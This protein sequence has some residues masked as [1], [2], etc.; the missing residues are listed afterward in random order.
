MGPFRTAPA[1]LRAAL[2]VAFGVL[3]L[4]QAPAMTVAQVAPLFGHDRGLAGEAH[5]HAGHD[6]AGQDDTGHASGGHHH[7]HAT[8]DDARPAAPA[9]LAACQSVDCCV[10]VSPPA[11]VAPALIAV[12]LGTLASQAPARLNQFMPER[13]DPPP[14]FS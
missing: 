4:L 14:R 13:I 5:R 10:G 9:P 8:D 2:A 1:C 3:T 6:L 7:H 11:I 12:P